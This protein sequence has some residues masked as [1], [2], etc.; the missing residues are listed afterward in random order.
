MFGIDTQKLQT[1]INYAKAALAWV[2][3]ALQAIADKLG[4]TLP[5]PPPAPQD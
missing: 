4:I 5:K 1:D 2:I 3:A